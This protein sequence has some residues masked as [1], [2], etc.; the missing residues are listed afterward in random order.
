MG[1]PIDSI[2][3]IDLNGDGNHTVSFTEAE[4]RTRVAAD[5]RIVREVLAQ[6]GINVLWDPDVDLQFVAA[7]SGFDGELVVDD[8]AFMTMLGGDYYTPERDDVEIFYVTQLSNETRDANTGVEIVREL[9]GRSNNFEAAVHPQ[10]PD[11]L[12]VSNDRTIFTVAHEIV[13]NL[14][15]IGH[16]SEADP[17]RATNLMRNGA[18]ALIP[19]FTETAVTPLNQRRLSRSII[20]DTDGSV[21][22]QYFEIWSDPR[23]KRSG[24]GG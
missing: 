11:S 6:A 14:G 10:A 12:F 5:I 17:K 16:I 23:I 20:L 19:V 13:H 3:P 9:R 15:Q 21:L 8:S 2:G 24:N 22:D 4:A 18:F 7:P 1:E